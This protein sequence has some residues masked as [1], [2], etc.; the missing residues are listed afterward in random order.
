MRIAVLLTLSILAAQ[1]QRDAKPIKEGFGKGAY[2]YGSVTIGDAYCNDEPGYTDAARVARI[3]GT[4]IVEI[5]V[6][7]NGTAADARVTKSL[8]PGLDA[9]ALAA[10]RS[11]RFKPSERSRGNPVASIIPKT[12]LFRLHPPGRIP[13]Q[14]P[15]PDQSTADA[16]FVQDAL[17]SKAPGIKPPRIIRQEDP[18]YT[19]AAMRA[20]IQGVVTLDVVIGTDGAVRAART[21]T[22]LDDKLGLDNQAIEAV[23]RWR[24]E[25]AMLDG[26]PVPIVVLLEIYFRLH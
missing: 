13:G 15:P 1:V 22:S 3:E 4:V 8:D 25:P 2:P 10:V 6:L 7:E 12:F 24:F 26:Q 5:V 11:C 16:L 14:A 23:K 20:R 18:K 21:R 19:S 9:R 17:S